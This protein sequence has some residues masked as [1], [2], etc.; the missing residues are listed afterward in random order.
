MAAELWFLKEP[1]V[2][3]VGKTGNVMLQKNVNHFPK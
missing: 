3:E 2:K 1:F